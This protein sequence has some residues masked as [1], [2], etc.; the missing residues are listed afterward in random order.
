[1]EVTITR[2]LYRNGDSEFLINGR[3]CRLKDIHELFT[4]TGLGRD[5]LSIISQ[6]R[7]ESVFN[8]KAEE[9][10]AIFEEAAGVLKYKTRRAE[11]ESKL[12]TTQD[13]LDRLEDIIF[14][15]NGQL[16][17]LRAQRDVAL[18][19]QDLEAQRSELAL[20]V[21]V[22]QLLEE[23]EKYEQAKDD[24]NVVETELST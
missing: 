24:L 20:S 6:G 22:A 23:K 4:D 15:L 9:R 21:L 10:R 3:K 13:N 5:S 19:F 14:E 8:S 1:M 12:Q 11:T 2:R 17:P 18:R 7:I 16:T